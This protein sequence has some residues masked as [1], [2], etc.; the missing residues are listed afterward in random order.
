VHGI[1]IISHGKS[2]ARAI[3][4]AI[5][6]AAQAAHAGLDEHIATRLA[7]TAEART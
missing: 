2:T 1:S 4:N 5:R 3:K 7:G 6:V